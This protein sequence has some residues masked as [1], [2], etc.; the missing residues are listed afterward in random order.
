MAHTPGP[1]WIGTGDSERNNEIANVR[2]LMVWG[3]RFTASCGDDARLVTAAP[4]LLAACKELRMWISEHSARVGC[5]YP[6][7]L[8]D[9]AYAA[10][11]KAQGDIPTQK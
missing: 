7:A 6:C 5:G 2:G 3:P 8:L 9:Q 1:W 10:I 4:D 11:A